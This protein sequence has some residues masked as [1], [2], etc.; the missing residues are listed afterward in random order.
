[1]SQSR[2]EERVKKH[3]QGIDRAYGWMLQTGWDVGSIFEG[4]MNDLRM[5]SQTALQ[6]SLE[7]FHPL[8]KG[9]I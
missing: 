9:Q 4:W 8:L 2:E 3:S 1:M 6:M 5:N 7:I